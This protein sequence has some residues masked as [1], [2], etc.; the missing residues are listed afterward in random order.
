[1]ILRLATALFLATTGTVA[2]TN[3][4][5]DGEIE[6]GKIVRQI[7]DTRPVANYT[8]S[9]VL[10]IRQSK[11]STIEIPVRFE[12][13]ITPTHWVSL[14]QTAPANG[15]SPSARLLVTRESG[16]NRYELATLAENDACCPT[17]ARLTRGQAMTPFA[18][19]DFWV[20]DLGLEFFHFF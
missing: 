16:G 2:A 12:V 3:N 20:A 7:L 8:N 15:A 5:P 1:M 13:F 17:N 14:Y 9:G 11:N 10:K 18:G 4:L 6:G 19:S